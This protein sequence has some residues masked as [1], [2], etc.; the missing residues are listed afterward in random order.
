MADRKLIT[1]R[2]LRALRP[3]PAGTRVEIWDSRVSGFG[4]RVTDRKDANP[5]RRGKAGKIIFILYARFAPG[6]APTRRTIGVYGDDAVSL[7]QARRTAGEWRSQIAKGIDPAVVETE[8]RAAEGRE[9]ALRIKHAFSS[10]AEVF[11]TDKL[12][13]ERR[14]KRAKRDFRSIFIVAWGDRPISEIT[15]AD[16]LAI[17]NAKKRGAPSMAKALLTLIGRFFTWVIDSRVYGLDRSPCEGLTKKKIIGETVSRNRRLNDAELFAFER[18]AWRMGYPVGPVYRLLLHSGL[19]LNECARLSWSE[20][21]D[22]HIIVPASRMKGRDGKATE[23]LVPLST[24]AQEIIASLPRY[25]G[26]PFL[27][28]LSAGKRPVA[29]TNQHKRDLDRRML[30]TLKALARR[31]GDNDHAITLP[32]WVNHDLR[33]TLRSGLSALRVPQNVCE[34]ILAH[35]PPGIVGT[36]DVYQ[37][38]DEKREAL[39]AWAKRLKSIVEPAPDDNVIPL[40]GR[41]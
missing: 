11:F 20:V 13:H 28:S 14:G 33:R 23:H 24:T 39:E 36:Y 22:G 21:H 18:A 7:E 34:A 3:A 38:Q 4:V 31:R 35:R 16:V 30:R 19:R 6:A 2:M 41:R 26:G 27:F 10:V 5:A 12:A 1:D 15:T 9:R 40:R 17:I 29:M 32:E 25:R 37:Y 8:A